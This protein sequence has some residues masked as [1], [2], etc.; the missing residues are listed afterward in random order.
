[1]K[2]VAILT[3][4]CKTNQF[5]S[6]AMHEALTRENYTLVPSGAPADVYVINTCTVTG[7]ADAESRRLIRRAA[8]SNPLATIVVTGCYAQV[9]AEAIKDLPGVRLIIGNEEK[10][11]LVHLLQRVDD[12]Q[13]IKISDIMASSQATSLAL[14]S[15][16]EHTR[17]FLQIQNGCEAFCAYCIVPYARGRSRSVPQDEVLAG[18]RRFADRGFQEIVLTGI[19]LGAYGLDL[20]PETNLL[21]LIREIDRAG[22]VPRLRIG[23]LEPQE[24]E[25][26]F[27]HT[28][29]TGRSLCPHL[30][31]PLQAGCDTVLQRMNRRYSTAQFQELVTCLHARIADLTLGFD[32]IAGF[33]GETDAEF[34]TGYDFIARLPFAYCHVFPYSARNG[35]PAATMP[36][37]VPPAVIK[38][39]AAALRALGEQKNR[40]WLERQ[41]GK[42]IPVLGQTEHGR[43]ILQGIGRNY[44]TVEYPADTA[45]INREVAVR[46][47]S[48]GN[49]KAQGV[50]VG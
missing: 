16:A 17:A 33:P 31:I 45:L 19:H 49:G 12:R 1:M 36:G 32:L 39:R 9:A 38:E 28:L 35:T 50:V 46:I 21:Y 4:G 42:T 22:L 24:I 27:M 30:H 10:R 23:S 26:D 3:L 14:E 13:Q 37:Q 6:A 43:G 48:V 5:E 47:T 20:Q 11:D 15:F 18:V 7:K 25:P 34:R 29:A 2:T 44:L 8:R 41:R 40:D